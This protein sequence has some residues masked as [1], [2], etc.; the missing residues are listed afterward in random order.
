MELL[1]SNHI[2][3]MDSVKPDHRVK[4]VIDEW[5]TWFDVEPGTNPGFLY[6]QSTMR[7]AVVA[8]LTLNI[9]NKH[10]DRIMMANIAQ[11]VR[12]EKWY[13]QTLAVYRGPLLYVLP[14]E[15]RWEYKGEL[16]LCDRWAY[17]LSQ[18]NY[19][20]LPEYGFT[21][22]K[23]GTKITATAFICPEWGEKH[24]SADQPPVRPLRQADK[25][26]VHITLVPYG[27]SMLRIAQFP[28]GREE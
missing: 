5:G 7:D 24:G 27:T 17:P 10:A 23:T 14:I 18:C 26:R 19:A 9:F 25:E 22:D 20:L 28:Y 13:H 11:E 3:M 1:V 6:Q 15:T 21:V 4:L 12:T 2:K 8:G 16:P